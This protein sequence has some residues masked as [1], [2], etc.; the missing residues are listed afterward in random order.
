[1]KHTCHAKNCK[2][3]VPPRL[4]M[5]KRHW[6]MVPRDLQAEVWRTYRRGQEKWGKPG[7]ENTE[8]PSMEYLKAAQAAIEA[9]AEKEELQ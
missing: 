9:V 8:A 4:L 1:M 6:F 5:C 7:G 2:V 3:Q